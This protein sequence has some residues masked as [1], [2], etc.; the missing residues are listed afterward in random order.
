MEV[1]IRQPQRAAGVL[2]TVAQVV[3]AGEPLSAYFP[4]VHPRHCGHSLVAGAILHAIAC[5]SQYKH[6]LLVLLPSSFVTVPTL[7]FIRIPLDDNGCNR[8]QDGQ[9]K[10]V[11]ARYTG[12]VLLVLAT[13]ATNV[14]TSSHFQ[15]A[16]PSK[17]PSSGA[18]LSSMDPAVS[19]YTIDGVELGTTITVHDQ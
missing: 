15:C 11:R 1:G 3:S 2:G 4:F 14:V 6:R 18:P 9:R 10:C 19:R 5:E 17:D 12:P 13:M 7:D 16:L 8:W